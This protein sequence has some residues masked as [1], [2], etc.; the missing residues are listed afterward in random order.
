MTNITR[1]EGVIEEDRKEVGF[2]TLNCSKDIS[3]VVAR[4]SSNFESSTPAISLQE[5][6]IFSNPHAI[7][8]S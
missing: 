4:A 1:K 6:I 7:V 3:F 5:N 8:S 2:C